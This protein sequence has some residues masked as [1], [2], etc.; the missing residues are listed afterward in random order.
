MGAKNAIIKPSYKEDYYSGVCSWKGKVWQHLLENE[1]DN[2]P[3]KTVVCLY[4]PVWQ[5]CVSNKVA[6][7]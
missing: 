1:S 6:S 3:I 5:D 2:S 4:L 7:L